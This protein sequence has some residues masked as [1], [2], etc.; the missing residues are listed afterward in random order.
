[1]SSSSMILSLPR[2][3]ALLLQLRRAVNVRTLVH[4]QAQ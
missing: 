4:M 3:R 2:A 1:M